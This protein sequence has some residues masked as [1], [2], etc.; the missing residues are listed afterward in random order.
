MYAYLTPNKYLVYFNA[1]GGNTPNPT[2]KLV[3]YDS[4]YGSLASISRTGYTF[5][6]WYTSPSG[7]T[8]IESTTEVNITSDQTLYAHW[9]INSYYVDVNT[10]VDGQASSGGW[11]GFTFDVYI[12]GV[13]VRTGV[14]DY[15]EAVQYGKSVRIVANSKDGYNLTNGDETQT[16]GEGNIYF[17]PTWTKEETGDNNWYCCDPQDDCLALEAAGAP[18]EE[19]DAC[20]DD[21]Y[22]NCINWCRADE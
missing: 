20:W 9:T 17:S 16:V 2:S 13:R 3:T 5:D 11:T 15:Y 6:G 4:T 21:H 12:D 18:E 7:G 10:V 22:T 14:I 8:K 1:N 19:I